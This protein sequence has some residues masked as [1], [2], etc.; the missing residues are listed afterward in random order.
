[1]SFLLN[2]NYI[3]VC[4]Y[5]GNKLKFRNPF[6]MTKPGKGVKKD[7]AYEVDTSTLFGFFVTYGRKFWTLSTANILYVV[8]NFPFFFFLAA[9]SGFFDKVS[10]APAS[11]LYAPLYGISLY[12]ANPLANVLLSVLSTEATVSIH[13]TATFVFYGLALLLL[14]TFGPANAGLAA[15][16]R[17]ICRGDMVFFSQDFFGTIKRNW[18]SSTIL[19]I[20]DIGASF[21]FVYNIMFYYLNGASLL[22]YVTIAL[23]IVYFC[24]RFYMYAILVTFKLSLV[25]VLK[26]S[27]IFALI[28][29]KRN[30]MAILGVAFAVAV[31]WFIAIL[32]FPVGLLLPFLIT[33]ATISYV[34]IYAIFPNIK[35]YMIDPYYSSPKSSSSSSEEPIFKDRG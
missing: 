20:I 2:G 6:D 23:F 8:V 34:S 24:M 3:F 18:L 14:L 17:N 1:M 30:I 25:K 19:G 28:G 12:G 16:C 35:K 13:T 33:V 26:D 9:V 11:P 4:I 22:I 32:Y 27:F 5:G 15:I 29:F 31:N 21:L 7:D 10:S